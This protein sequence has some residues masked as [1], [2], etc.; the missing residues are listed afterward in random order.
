M[1]ND[2]LGVS[3]APTREQSEMG[4]RRGGLE[5]I[6]QAIRVL[7]LRLPRFMGAR[8]PSPLV[9][10]QGPGMD[11][12]LSAVFQTLAK[13]LGASMQPNAMTAPGLPTGRTPGTNAGPNRGP[14]NVPGLPPSV[15]DTPWTPQPTPKPSTRTHWQDLPAAGGG[16]RTSLPTISERRASKYDEPDMGYRAGQRY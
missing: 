6:P 11:P 4:E 7:S 3:F 14:F 10:G 15:P 5:G 12:Y 13:T 2:G 9:S 16:Q 1:T 8:S